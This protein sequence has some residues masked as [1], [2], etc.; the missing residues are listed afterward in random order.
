MNFQTT[1]DPLKNKVLKNRFLT[2]R[3]EETESMENIRFSLSAPANS[4]IGREMI[5]EFPRDDRECPG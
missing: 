5:F 4:L 2:D 1:F 3:T